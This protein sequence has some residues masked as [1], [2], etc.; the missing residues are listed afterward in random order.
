MYEDVDAVSFDYDNDGDLD[1]Y[2]MSGGN[3]RPEGDPQLEDRIYINDGSAK[4]SRLEL[5][6]IRTNGGSVSSADFDGDG[7]EDLFIGNRSIP[8]AYGISPDSFILKNNGDKGF[9]IVDKQKYGMVTDSKWVDLNNDDLLDLVIVGDWMPV[10]ILMNTGNLKFENKSKDFGLED[11]EGLWNVISVADLDANGFQDLILGNAGLN[12]KWKASHERPVNLYVHDFD[13]NEQL[14]PIIFY[15]FFGEYV[16]FPSKD[17]LVGQLPSLKKKFLDYN[18]FSKIQSIK[19][20]TGIKEKDIL[21]SKKISELRSM[22]LFNSGTQ[23]KAVPV[24]NEAQMSTIEDIY[25]DEKENSTDVLFVGNYLGFTTELGESASNSSGMITFNNKGE[26]ISYT[27]LPIPTN[28][29]CR[30]IEKLAE[31][32]FLVVANN[33]KSYIFEKPKTIK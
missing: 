22:V 1:L 26:Q 5:T 13:K 31:N 2:V 28:L 12:L 8:G 25:I 9:G 10:T 21:V 16:P 32:K 3:D 6:L 33:D 18:K 20:L 30:K 7:L 23:F 29:N 19:D 17:K 4:F 27:Q 15:D 11:T 14:D 24:R